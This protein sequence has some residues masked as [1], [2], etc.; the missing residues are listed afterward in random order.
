MQTDASGILSVSS[1]ERL[2][3]IE[4]DFKR[5]LSA[6]LALNPIN[7][8]WNNL[9]GLDQ[10]N[11]YSGFSAQNVQTSI[12]EAVGNDSK[13]YLTLNDRPILAALVNAIK[14]LQKE[15]ETLKQSN[16]A[17]LDQLDAEEKH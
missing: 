17:L 3:I 7:Y 13:G 6:I 10:A 1:D 5:G 14:E 12:P 9:S 8:R 16:Q 2:K 15:V 4:G 11:S